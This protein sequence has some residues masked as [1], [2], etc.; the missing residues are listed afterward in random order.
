MLALQIAFHPK[1]G[2]KSSAVGKGKNKRGGKREGELNA[3][4]EGD[5]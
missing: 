4:T 2:K 3:H 1:E 5:F